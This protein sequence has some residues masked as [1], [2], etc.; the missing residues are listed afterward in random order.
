MAPEERC[1]AK[2][3]SGSAAA[4]PPAA[5]P[6]SPTPLQQ[7]PPPPVRPDGPGEPLAPV[8]VPE[9]GIVDVPER[10]V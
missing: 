3:M 10:R 6:G 1:P 2:A 4:P 7:P 8:D 5:P 9:P